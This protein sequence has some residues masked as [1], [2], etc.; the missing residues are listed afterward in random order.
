MNTIVLKSLPYDLSFKDYTDLRNVLRSYTMLTGKQ[1]QVL[2]KEPMKLFG[3]DDKVVH[4]TPVGP[5]TL[6]LIPDDNEDVYIVE[7][8]NGVVTNQHKQM[9]NTYTS[10]RIDLSFIDWH[11]IFAGLLEASYEAFFS[12][13]SQKT[14]AKWNKDWSVVYPRIRMTQSISPGCLALYSNSTGAVAVLR[15]EGTIRFY[16]EGDDEFLFDSSGGFEDFGL[17]SEYLKMGK[18]KALEKLHGLVFDI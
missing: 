6:G 2:V 11:E 5:A 8:S 17:Y 12:V 4:E 18:E 14:F 7:D 10:K 15:P 16:K 9:L 3:R 1:V 13:Y